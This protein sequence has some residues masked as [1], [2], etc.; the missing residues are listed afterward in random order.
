MS[1]PTPPQPPELPKATPQQERMIKNFQ[2][3]K[4]NQDQ[5]GEFNNNFTPS[6]VDQSDSNSVSEAENVV[7]Q[8]GS[9]LN[10]QQNNNYDTFFRFSGGTHIPTTTLTLN[11]SVLSDDNYVIT[12]GINI[13]LGGKTSKLAKREVELATIS[14]EAS[15]CTGL[16]KANVDISGVKN[17]SFCSGYKTVA[18]APKPHHLPKK[19]QFDELKLL[20]TQQQKAM[21]EQQ[22]TIEALQLRLI[23]MNNQ[24]TVIKGSY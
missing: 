8:S 23:Q 19:T 21:A 18:V 20:I 5:Q 7:S 6:S 3:Q 16:I 24:P 12:G 1:L 4:Q 15:V 11:G 13:P 9:L 14:K 10:I 17:L 2:E 22:R